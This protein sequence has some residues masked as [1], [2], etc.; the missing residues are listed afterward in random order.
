M[1]LRMR[2]PR[3][4]DFD[5]ENRP[6]SYL[7][8]DFTTSEIT[9]IAAC[10]ADEPATVSSVLLGVREPKDILTWFA[11]LYDGAD[12]V[13]GHYILMH[14]LPIIN[15]ALLEYGMRPLG[16]KLVSDTKVHLIG[17]KGV[18][19]SQESLSDI[20]GTSAPKVHMTQ[21]KWREANRL[22]PEGI[23]ETKARVEGDV[24][25]HMQMRERLIAGGYLKAPV[26][27]AGGV[28]R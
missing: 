16:P 9:A 1:A 5:I 22:T 21:A 8:S 26:L 24:I 7:G 17:G 23:A 6:L 25:Q 14:D 4:L 3:I 19:K 11:F 28:S 27:W 15:G 13:T 2:A 18:S 12:I 20:V 10:W